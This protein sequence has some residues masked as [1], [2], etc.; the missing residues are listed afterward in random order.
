MLTAATVT[1]NVAAYLVNVI[2]SR[3]NLKPFN[4]NG[5]IKQTQAL[6]I[7]DGIKLKFEIEG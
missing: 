3:G 5:S 7:F 2:R 4:L 1:L 6:Y